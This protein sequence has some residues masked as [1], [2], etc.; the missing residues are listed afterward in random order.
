MV[1]LVGQFKPR[2]LDLTRIRERVLH[3]PEWSKD[4]LFSIPAGLVIFYVGNLSVVSD[5]FASAPLNT[6]NRPLIE[7]L[8]PR[9]TRVNALSDT[10]WFTGKTLAEFYDSLERR[11]AGIP[12]PSFPASKEIA[13]ARR[14]GTALYHYTVAATRHDDATA[15]HYKAEVRELVP[16]VISAA[17]ARSAKKNVEISQQELEGILRQQEMLRHQLEEMQ[18]RLSKL[19]GTDTQR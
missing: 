7:F 2:L 3:L 14:A 19:S 4:P 10:D 6:D 9:L 13:A 8:A 11:L 5:L 18:R 12:D 15:A 17:G 1:G 16:E